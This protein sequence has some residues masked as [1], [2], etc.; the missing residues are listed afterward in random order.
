[1]RIRQ[2]TYLFK[3]KM[4]IRD[5][6]IATSDEFINEMNNGTFEYESVSYTHLDVYKRQAVE[7]HA[8]DDDRIKRVANTDMIFFNFIVFTF[9]FNKFL[10]NVSLDFK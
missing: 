7:E 5:R 6:G 2:E 8:T 4:C 3:E 1:M 10:T 9:I